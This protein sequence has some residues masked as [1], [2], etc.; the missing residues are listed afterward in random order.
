MSRER[1]TSAALS[2]LVC[3]R[4]AEVAGG[5]VND[6]AKDCDSNCSHRLARIRTALG[7][8]ESNKTRRAATRAIHGRP[9]AR[10][11]RRSA[12]KR[13]R[14]KDLRFCAARP[15][16]AREERLDLSAP[17]GKQERRSARALEFLQLRP[18]TEGDCV[19]GSFTRKA[20]S[21]NT[22]LARVRVNRE[23]SCSS[24]SRSRILITNGERKKPT[25]LSQRRSSLKPS[26]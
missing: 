18:S 25:T 12:R 19:A 17:A 22:S 2:Q 10:H 11:F 16:P 6:E 7:Q 15:L 3:S 1:V 14:A 9:M 24:A 20:L 4:A 13:D 21:F 8:R 5:F 23:K 26:R